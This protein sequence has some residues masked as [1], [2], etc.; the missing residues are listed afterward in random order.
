MDI[1]GKVCTNIRDI[2]K[3]TGKTQEEFAK[4]LDISRSYLG[5]I[6]S[7][8]TAPTL[9]IVLSISKQTGV[10]VHKIL[11]IKDEKLEEE[12]K[13]KNEAAQ[14]LE[15]LL[16][17]LKVKGIDWDSLIDINTEFIIKKK[18]ANATPRES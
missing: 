15:M 18:G 6:E 13:K 17:L 5:M 2:R 1:Q 12:M 9:E 7:G 3:N 8:K 16:G 14:S 10:S 4:L 11:G